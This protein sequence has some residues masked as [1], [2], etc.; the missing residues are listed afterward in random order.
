MGRIRR[1]WEAWPGSGGH[2]GGS[3]F[4]GIEEP[5]EEKE[6]SLSLVASAGPILVKVTLSDAVQGRLEQPSERS[7]P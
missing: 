7:A 6:A 5:P 2:F 1:L 4:G 3:R